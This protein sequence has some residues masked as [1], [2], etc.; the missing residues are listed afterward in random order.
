MPA[1]GTTDLKVFAAGGKCI[2]HGRAQVRRWSLNCDV[3]SLNIKGDSRFLRK[4][5]PATLDIE[6]PEA[7]WPET[8]GQAASPARVRGHPLHGAGG[9]GAHARGSRAQ[10]SGAAS[11]GR[12]SAPGRRDCSQH[13]CQAA[14]QGASHA[15]SCGMSAQRGDSN[16]RPWTMCLLLRIR[17]SRAVVRQI[18]RSC[19]PTRT[20]WAGG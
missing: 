4:W 9:H 6:P 13:C 8:K 11:D 12:G 17:C 16:G 18:R 14:G 7:L 20:R 10:A 1:H 15:D 5:P 19:W 2:G 3:L